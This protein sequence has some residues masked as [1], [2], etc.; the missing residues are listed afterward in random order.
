MNLNNKFNL[1]FLN[2]IKLVITGGVL[3][4]IMTL[5]GYILYI[6]F[7]AN[8][9]AVAPKLDG[10]FF[11]IVSSFKSESLDFSVLGQNIEKTLSK[12]NSVR[13]DIPSIGSGQ[14][15]NPFSP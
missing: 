3:I 6:Q 7:G 5:A 11:T 13:N 15:E 14:R 1:N 4:I 12:L 8:D 2:N 9:I 10:E